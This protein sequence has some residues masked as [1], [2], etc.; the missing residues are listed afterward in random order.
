MENRNITLT[1]TSVGQITIFISSIAAFSERDN[2]TDIYLHGLP[3]P[4][5]V[6]ESYNQ[7]QKKLDDG[8]STGAR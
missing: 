6:N 5:R 2:G 3:Q 7:V 8:W 1:Q 4:I